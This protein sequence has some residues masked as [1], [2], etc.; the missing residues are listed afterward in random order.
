MC[1]V[2]RRTTGTCNPG[3]GD[4]AGTEDMEGWAVVLEVGVGV[5]GTRIR[6]VI[7]DSY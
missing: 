3:G 7:C 1:I 2:Y 5:R 4:V 6:Q